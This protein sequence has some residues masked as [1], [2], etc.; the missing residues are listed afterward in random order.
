M[1][2]HARVCG[3]VCFCTLSQCPAEYWDEAHA[4]PGASLK[5]WFWDRCN[6]NQPQICSILHVK[7]FVAGLAFYCAIT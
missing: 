7:F 5:P 6:T 1:F 4:A 2:M 3:W